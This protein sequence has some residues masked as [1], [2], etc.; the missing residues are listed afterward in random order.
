MA[1]RALYPGSFD[2]VTNG[3]VDIVTRAASLFDEVIVAVYDTPSK[4]LLFNTQERVAMFKEAVKGMKNVRVVS[5]KGLTVDEARRQRA[6]VMVRGLRM[7]SDFEYEF[8]LALMNKQLAPDIETITLMTSLEY[9]FLSSS[10]LKEARSLGGDVTKL[11]PANVANA[12]QRKLTPKSKQ[13]KGGPP[14]KP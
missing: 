6:R 11:V 12:L 7:G 8:E 13:R 14:S 2:P 3:H 4:T 5:Y 10:L 1:L 9:Q